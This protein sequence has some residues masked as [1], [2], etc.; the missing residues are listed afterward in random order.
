MEMASDTTLAF[1]SGPPSIST[2]S[3]T[4][5]FER[6]DGVLKNFDA[7]F[8]VIKEQLSSFSDRLGVVESSV[9]AMTKSYNEEHSIFSQMQFDINSIE[10]FIKKQHD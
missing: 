8:N 4:T 3:M 5:L 7:G 10:D 1:S 6:F 2:D 9:A